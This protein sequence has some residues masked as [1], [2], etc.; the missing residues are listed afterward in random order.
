MPPTKTTRDL[1]TELLTYPDCMRA[2]QFKAQRGDYTVSTSL[3]LHPTG[4]LIKDLTTFAQPTSP[5]SD[6]DRSRVVELL[7]Q[8]S[9]GTFNL[10]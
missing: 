3:L 10:K 4:E 7:L 5:L 6:F 9:N 1:V 8:V 2:V